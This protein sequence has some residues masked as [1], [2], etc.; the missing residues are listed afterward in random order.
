[1]FDGYAPFTFSPGVASDM[2]TITSLDD[3]RA[4]MARLRRI[5]EHLQQLLANC[6][7]D[8]VI[9]QLQRKGNGPESVAIPGLSAVEF[10]PAWG[11]AG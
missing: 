8:Y 7:A 9:D 1:M 10:P 11:R 4:C 3:R 6:V 5:R 2:P